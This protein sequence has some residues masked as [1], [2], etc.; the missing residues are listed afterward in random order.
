MPGIDEI[1]GPQRDGMGAE[2]V[3]H[4]EPVGGDWTIVNS[5]H[6]AKKIDA[7][8]FSFEVKAPARGDVK[9]TYRVRIKWC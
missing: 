8:T 9:V 3:K 6:P 5:S 7:H 1:H 4:F 2:P